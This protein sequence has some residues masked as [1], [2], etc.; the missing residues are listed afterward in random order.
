MRLLAC[1]VSVAFTLALTVATGA[2]AADG[3]V[4]RVDRSQIETALGDKFAFRTTVRNRGSGAAKGYIAHLNVLSYDRGVYVDPEDWSAKRT[5]YFSPIRPGG[6]TAITWRMQAVSSG[7]FAVYVAVLP[8]AGSG[9]LPTTGS[10]ISLTVAER[11]TLNSEGILPLVVGIPALLGCA[12]L[13][14]R[15]R[16]R[17]S[18]G[19]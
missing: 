18:F 2:S 9:E 13:G 14:L 10:A 19:R 16:R 5:R 12:W 1:A 6:S 15:A 4:A 3:L 7:H 11:T 17:G 8:P